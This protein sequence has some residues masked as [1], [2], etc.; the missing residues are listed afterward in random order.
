[1]NSP[2]TI[3]LPRR[4]TTK[5]NSISEFVLGSIIGDGGFAKVRK[6]IHINSGEK[7]AIK[8][9]RLVTL[10]ID[11]V[12]NVEKELEIHKSLDSKYIIKLVD[13]FLEAEVVYLV[14]ELAS[15][16]NLFKFLNRNFPMKEDLIMKFW[17]QTVRAIDHLHNNQIFMRDLKPENV[18]LDENLDVK[19]CDFGWAC[20]LSDMEYR[21]LKGGTYI[22]MSPESLKGEI[23]GLESDMWSLG[24]LLYELFHN[25]EPF[26]LGVNASEQLQYVKRGVSTYTSRLPKG[27]KEMIESLLSVEQMK[28][29]TTGQVLKSELVR[30]SKHEE[31]KFLKG[32]ELEPGSLIRVLSSSNL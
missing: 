30:T 22:Y 14:L 15:K 21:K 27:Y 10:G 11:D 17:S 18:L 12:E 28:R 31:V 3:N 26:K 24:V 6:A 32:N 7:F 19:L 8:V 13:Y 2:R 9:I 25:R 16:G 1:M 20:R 4:R 5:F 29:P 23:Q